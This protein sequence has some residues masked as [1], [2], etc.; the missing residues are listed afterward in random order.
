MLR[1]SRTEA[2]VLHRVVRAWVPLFIL[3]WIVALRVQEPPF[4]R[5]AQLPVF[6]GGVEAALL[7]LLA[8]VPLVWIVA[9]GR[10]AHEW[11]LRAARSP[12]GNVLSNWLGLLAYGLCLALLMLAAGAALDLVYQGVIEWRAPGLILLEAVL[13]LAPLAALAPAVSYLG[14]S[15]PMLMV[16]WLLLLGF[17]MARGY[18]VPTSSLLALE[19]D[20]ADVIGAFDWGPA[21]ATTVAGLLLSAAL[22]KRR[23]RA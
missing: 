3:V 23:L 6:W 22:A 1:R 13:L 17:S 16:V 11:T 9:R 8:I 18:P 15:T 7:L 5:R 2:L 14:F 21:S 10:E 4:L 19:R 20:D 12:A